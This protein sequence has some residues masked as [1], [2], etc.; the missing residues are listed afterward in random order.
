MAMTLQKS[1]DRRIF[2][3]SSIAFSTA[4][5]ATGLSA[6]ENTAKKRLLFFTKSSGFQHDSV[7]RGDDG[8]C[9]ADRVVLELGRQ[10]GIDVVC[11]K[12]GRLFDSEYKSFDA[13]FFCTS[14]DLTQIGTDNEPAMS[15]QGKQNLLDAV[16]AGKGFI[17]CH[18]AS[19]TFHSSGPSAENQ[20][21]RDPYIQMIGGE[22]IRH[23]AQQMATMVLHSPAFPGAPK[24]SFSMHEEWYSLK[25][26]AEN[27]HVILAQ[28]TEGM[29]D[30][31][32][33]RPSFPATWARRH[34]Q[35]R[36]FYSSMGHREDVWA[37]PIFGELISGAMR[38][39]TGLVEFDA[40]Q[41]MAEVC[42]GANE[43]PKL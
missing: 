1:H 10:L 20:I 34:G 39:T 23:G 15:A 9:F 19:D 24:E 7:K 37:N 17:G 43:M 33:H 12:D 35:G 2:L 22:F 11:S 16:H 21:V 32:Y 5:L 14:G 41:N 30:A 31:D 28:K 40:K 29:R 25:N 8:N 18:C 38:W 6:Q 26:F 13:F 42:P 4:T 3:K 27:L 36:V